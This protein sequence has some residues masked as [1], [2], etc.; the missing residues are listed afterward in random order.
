MGMCSLHRSSVAAL[1]TALVTL[2]L[3]VSPLAHRRRRHVRHLCYVATHNP[4]DLSVRSGQRK[5]GALWVE[6]SPSAEGHQDGR[7]LPTTKGSICH[8]GIPS[9][10]P[11]LFIHCDFLV[12]GSSSSCCVSCCQ[13]ALSLP[14]HIHKKRSHPPSCAHHRT[15]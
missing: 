11:L 8:W 2:R 4:C 13:L 5:G 9:V 1:T 15:F 7:L 6:L 10:F 14:T 3:P 12:C